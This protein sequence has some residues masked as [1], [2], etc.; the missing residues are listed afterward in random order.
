MREERIEKRGRKGG[1]AGAGKGEGGGETE[2]AGCL[3]IR[4]DAAASHYLS[5]YLLVSLKLCRDEPY[6]AQV[7]MA[8]T[9]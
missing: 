6:A 3:W 9:V 7:K 1:Q 4:D 5:S 8:P 2:D